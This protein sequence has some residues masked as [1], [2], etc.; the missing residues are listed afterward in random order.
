MAGEPPDYAAALM[1]MGD[2]R[3][4]PIM[5]PAT[6]IFLRDR[7]TLARLL[8]EHRTPSIC[9]F[10]EVDGGGRAHELR[11]ELVDVFRDVAGIVDQVA[12]GAKA[13]ETSMRQLSHFHTA[14]NF[15]TAKALGLEI[16]PMLLARA[17][18]VIE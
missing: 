2:L 14:V 7:A 6:P 12:K 10:R 5:V 1:P 18:E 15:K 9:A 8:I 4:E 3:G 16:S 13:G 17:D 11:G